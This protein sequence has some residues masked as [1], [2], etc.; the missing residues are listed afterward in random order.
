METTQITRLGHLGDGLAADGTAIPF[1][2]PGETV[3]VVPFAVLTP[4]ADRVE[5]S[6]RYFETCGGCALQ[7]GS[8]AF[9]RQWKAEVVGR[10]LAAHGI[11]IEVPEALDFAAGLRRRAV[12]AG[13]RGRKAARLGFHVRASHDLIDIDDCP[14]LLPDFQALRPALLQLTLAAASRRGTVRLQVTATETGWDIDVSGGRVLGQVLRTHLAG[15]IPPDLA[16]LTWEGEPVLMPNAPMVRFGQARVPLP[17]KAFLQVSSQAGA[18]L[19]QLVRKALGEARRIADLFAGCGTFSLPLSETAEVHAVEG[20]AAML[21][22]LQAGWRGADGLQAVTTEM[23]DLFRR[24]LTKDELSR[25]QAVVID[26]PRAGA[27]AQS[28]VLAE[29]GPPVIAAVSC[30]PVSFARDAAILLAGGY[31]LDWVQP[32]D[33]FRWSPHIEIVARFSR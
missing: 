12:F 31:A 30:N 19:L 18:A 3:A 28:H 13:Q 25:F 9:L 29:A 10:A 17:P 20:D 27:E 4:S 21:D 8:D 1:T 7:H 2:L 15:M 26:P 14:L 5:P 11:E 23:R 32:V 22:A 24:P 6:C 33:Q 16:R